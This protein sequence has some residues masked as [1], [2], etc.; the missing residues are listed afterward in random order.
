MLA[1]EPSESAR[2]HA[3]ASVGALPAPA[4]LCGLFL[5]ALLRLAACYLVHHPDER[6]YTDAGITMVQTGDWLTPRRPDGSLRFN[7]PI[8]PYWCVAVSYTFFGIGPFASRLPFLLAGCGTIWM[9]YQLA[10]LVGQSEAAGRWAALVALGNLQ[11]VLAATRSI[12]DI[13]LGLFTT[14]SVYGALAVVVY[15]RR[16]WKSYAA[17]YLGM[18]LAIASK[19]VPAVIVIGAVVAGAIVY[20]KKWSDFK[21]Y[22]HWPTMA[23]GLCLAG[24]WF[25][26]VYVVHGSQ[27]L[28]EFAHDQVGTRFEVAPLAQLMRAG[29]FLLWCALAGLPWIVPLA[30]ARMRG[31]FTLDEP[32]QRT[33][34]ISLAT[35]IVALAI[36]ASFC[37]V[38]SARYIVPVVPLVAV[39]LGNMLASVERQK[40]EPILRWLLLALCLGLCA[41]G[42]AL[43][44]ANIQ[45]SHPWLAAGCA[46]AFTAIIFG[47]LIRNLGRHSGHAM[48]DFGLV[49][50]ALFPALCVGLFAFLTPD[51]GELIVQRLLQGEPHA[52]AVQLIGK[53]TLASKMRVFDHGHTP[54]AAL[55]FPPP[56]FVSTYD[57]VLISDQSKL[58][59]LDLREFQISEFPS[60]I[61]RLKERDV[62]HALCRGELGAYLGEHQ[63]RCYVA[64]RKDAQQSVISSMVSDANTEASFSR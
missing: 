4:F 26:T 43:T 54:L 3:A 33:A 30:V 16:D 27:S 55:E 10:K 20:G 63:K 25:A 24:G 53:P 17:M 44:A 29:A 57:L 14:L 56:N 36:A 6:H 28:G 38:V 35:G 23:L 64:V 5:L 48:V 12:P 58:K 62:L 50:L 13:L 32:R 8:L 40:I 61:G 7:K 22:L 31:R 11:L 60:G 47:V 45:T 59:Q 9:T 42:V 49:K 41:I 39:W 1:T 46:A 51:E 21:N 37:N 2:T 15:G 52:P 19:G 18:G 34:I